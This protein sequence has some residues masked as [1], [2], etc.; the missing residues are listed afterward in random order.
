[1]V[2]V[3]RGPVAGDG[4]LVVRRLDGPLSGW[5]SSRPPLGP[6]DFHLLRHLTGVVDLDAEIANRALKLRI[7]KEQLIAP[8]FSVRR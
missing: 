8:N 3:F 1:M 5:S 6:V 2:N 4:W 7:S